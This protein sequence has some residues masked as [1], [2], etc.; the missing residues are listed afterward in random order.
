MRSR[1]SCSSRQTAL[2]SGTRPCATLEAI[3]VCLHRHP[4]RCRRHTPPLPP[5]QHPRCPCRVPHSSI[6]PR[7]SQRIHC[8]L[9][10]TR[11]SS[12][13]LRCRCL[14]PHPTP[15][16]KPSS[17]P[18]RSHA[19][20]TSPTLRRHAVPCAVCFA[21]YFGG[22]EAVQALLENQR[23]R[24]IVALNSSALRGHHSGFL[25]IHATVAAGDMKTYEFLVKLPGIPDRLQS[26]ANP[27][28]KTRPSDP[29]MH[30]RTSPDSPAAA[31]SPAA[32][33]LAASDLAAYYHVYPSYSPRPSD[34]R[35]PRFP[36][37]QT[38]SDCTSARLLER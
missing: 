28:I 37:H 6:L 17:T 32:S 7:S 8:F 35:D 3:R 24:G 19:S 29:H 14:S 9:C 22:R 4:H 38:C 15:R 26:I 25:P 2:S 16:S 1:S 30:K 12:A 36:S 34:A 11:P 27:T 10:I 33:D 18:T 13:L 31:A 21:A 5:Q 23:T 20:H